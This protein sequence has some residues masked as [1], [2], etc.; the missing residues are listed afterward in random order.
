MKVGS[1]RNRGVCMNKHWVIGFIIGTASGF[2]V[3]YGV[4]ALLVMNSPGYTYIQE[5]EKSLPRDRHC[6][7]IAVEE[8]TE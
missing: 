3:A 2:L 5:C 7:L 6:V 4:I 1:R 8:T